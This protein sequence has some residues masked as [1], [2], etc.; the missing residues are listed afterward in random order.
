MHS[1][2]ELIGELEA[3]AL[4]LA[5][6]VAGWQQRI[7]CMQRLQGIAAGC[8]PHLQEVLLDNFRCVLAYMPFR[9]QFVT[10]AP[11]Y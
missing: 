10:N 4:P 11:S 3:M 8:S 5:G 9:Q 1:E 6:T 2:K 7:S